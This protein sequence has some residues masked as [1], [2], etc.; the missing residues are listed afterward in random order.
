LWGL[1]SNSKSINSS[2]ISFNIQFHLITKKFIEKILKEY[3]VFD[4]KKIQKLLKNIKERRK[5]KFRKIYFYSK[6]MFNIDF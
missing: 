4:F 2:L 6:Y 1:Q 5:K 3:S